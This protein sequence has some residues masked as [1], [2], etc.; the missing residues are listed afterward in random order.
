MGWKIF[1]VVVGIWI[2]VWAVYHP[3]EVHQI[4]GSFFASAKQ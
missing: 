3:G 1:W 2:L 4:V